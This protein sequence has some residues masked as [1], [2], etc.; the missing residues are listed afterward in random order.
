MYSLVD[1]MPNNRPKNRPENRPEIARQVETS[2][3]PLI[4]AENIVQSTK[5]PIA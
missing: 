2:L 1:K 4:S 3:L 5:N